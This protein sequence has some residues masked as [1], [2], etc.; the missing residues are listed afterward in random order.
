MVVDLGFAI[1]APIPTPISISYS[2]GDLVWNS[3]LRTP[4]SPSIH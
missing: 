3:S 2:A 4:E 1:P